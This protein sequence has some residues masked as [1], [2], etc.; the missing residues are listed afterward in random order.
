MKPHY[1]IGDRVR[2]HNRLFGCD[3]VGTILN[4]SEPRELIVSVR[5]IWPGK[6]IIRRSQVIEKIHNWRGDT[7]LFRRALLS[8][9]FDYA[10]SNQS[11]FNDVRRD[12]RTR[13]LKLWSG[14]G[15]LRAPLAQQW[16]LYDALKAAYGQRMLAT[17]FSETWARSFSLCVVLE[18]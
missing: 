17:Y 13:R 2:F 3:G 11:I 5:G 18:A 9:G 4:T 6:L 12:G 8:A 16:K 7:G 15:V 14:G 1:Y 10:A